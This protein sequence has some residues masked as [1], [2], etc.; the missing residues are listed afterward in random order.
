MWDINGIGGVHRCLTNELQ[1]RQC[2]VK[3]RHHAG[4]KDLLEMGPLDEV[5]F[6]QYSS[7]YAYTSIAK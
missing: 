4:K 5:T 7:D 3:V 6:P 2:L 1:N